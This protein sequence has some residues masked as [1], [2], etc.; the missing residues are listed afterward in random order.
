[1]RLRMRLWGIEEG[2]EREGHLPFNGRLERCMDSTTC[3]GVKRFRTTDYGL[4]S[5]HCWR[6]R[7][8]MRGWTERKGSKA[9]RKG[10]SCKYSLSL[11]SVLE[12]I[13]L[14]HISY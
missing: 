10:C 14:I 1:M 3:K 13:K 12:C 8:K 11:S 7:H 6:L 5:S 9:V 4:A 2:R